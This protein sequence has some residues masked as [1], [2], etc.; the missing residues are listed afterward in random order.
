MTWTPFDAAV[1][2]GVLRGFVQGRGSPVVLVHGGPSLSGD[3]IESLAAELVDGYQV[4]WYQQRSLAPSVLTGPFTVSQHV[5]DLSR[6]LDALGWERAWSVGHSWGG[7]LVIAHAAAHPE[8]LLGVV[9]VDPL[10]CVGDGGSA[11]FGQALEDRTDPAD[12]AR[13]EELDERAM[14]GDGT[15]EEALESLRLLWPAYFADPAAAPPMPDMT[16]SIAGYAAT[17]ESVTEGLPGLEDRLGD[18]RV[19]VRFVHGRGSPIPVTASTDTAARIPGATVAVVE[20]AGHFVWHERP[21]AVRAALDGL[22]AGR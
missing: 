9:S 7:H 16:M 15:P 21:G 14:A 5:D 10:G 8:R 18:I 22:V 11:E 12:L 4:A 13:A 6:V 17:W 3:Y 20:G 2:G 19:P 1:D